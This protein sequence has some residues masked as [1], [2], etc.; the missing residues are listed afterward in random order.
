MLRATARNADTTIRIMTTNIGSKTNGFEEHKRLL[1][2]VYES[3]DRE[4]FQHV[5][6]S[7]DSR[8]WRTV[9]VA[10]IN[11]G[12]LTLLAYLPIL[13]AS[14]GEQDSREIRDKLLIAAIEVAEFNHA[15]HVEKSSQ[16]LRWIWESH[17]HWYA[18][19]FLLIEASRRPWSPILERAWVA[20]QSEWLFPRRS[21]INKNLRIWI[22][23]RRLMHSARKHRDN[24]ID[25]LRGDPQATSKLDLE[26]QQ[27]PVPSSDTLYANDPGVFQRRWQHLVM[28]RVDLQSPP[29]LGTTKAA[30]ATGSS[31]DMATA[32]AGPEAS[33][34]NLWI[35]AEN[36][37]ASESQA[38]SGLGNLKFRSTEPMFTQSISTGMETGDPF[39]DSYTGSSD[40][41]SAQGNDQNIYPDFASWMWTGTDPSL[42]TFSY[43]DTDLDLLNPGINVDGG[44]NW[45]HWVEFAEAVE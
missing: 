12:K 30:H 33:C 20:L 9:A 25:R 11:Q 42:D 45:L 32:S 5:Q 23:L 37:S 14:P 21:S 15:L 26:A 2:E 1:N 35:P 24:E 44:M 29:E 40:H 6:N 38:E 13:F 10:R 43:A 8:Y 18:I 27:F 36:W 3:Y 4:Y 7:D 39:T 41:L 22:P 31:Y 16:H 17:T 34:S 19:V 28:P